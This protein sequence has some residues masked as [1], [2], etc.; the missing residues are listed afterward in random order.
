MTKNNT[1]TALIDYTIMKTFNKKNKKFADNLIA[2]MTSKSFFKDENT[3]VLKINEILNDI[4]QA[5]IDGISAIDLFG[6]EPK[7]VANEI[8]N[9]IPNQKVSELFKRYSLSILYLIVISGILSSMSTRTIQDVEHAYFSVL[10]LII[11]PISLLLFVFLIFKFINFISFTNTRN[12]NLL[13]PGIFGFTICLPILIF[14]ITFERTFD[15]RMFEFEIPLALANL[16]LPLM[17]AVLIIPGV[18]H[19]L[20]AFLFK[21]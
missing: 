18:Y 4:A 19:I 6:N 7:N 15:I 16:Q 1:T 2:F 10:S 14:L 8:M 5:E 12:G 20:K 13:I 21:K 9:A 3:I 11:T 17:L